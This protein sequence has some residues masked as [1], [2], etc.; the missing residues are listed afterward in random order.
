MSG[1]LMDEAVQK[2]EAS[3]FKVC[4]KYNKS[5]GM[6]I[7]EVDHDAL[8]KVHD[9]V[10]FVMLSTDIGILVDWASKARKIISR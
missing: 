3:I 8:K 7:R 4:K 9:K 10:N 2:A 5:C 6:L 1:K